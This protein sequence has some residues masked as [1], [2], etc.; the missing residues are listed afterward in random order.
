[1]LWV[2]SQTRPDL[3]QETCVVTNVIQSFTV[4][5]V[6]TIHDANKAIIK[7]FKDENTNS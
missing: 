1:M 2:A 5:T 3:S 6:K 7:L 4:K